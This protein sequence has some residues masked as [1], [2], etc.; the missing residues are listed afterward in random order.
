MILFR[1]TSTVEPFSITER[2]PSSRLVQFRSCRSRPPSP[3][4]SPAFRQASPRPL[5]DI[6]TVSRE[7]A[8]LYSLNANASISRE[9]ARDLA[10]TATYLFTRGNRLPVIRNINLVPSGQQL[11]DGR[12]VFGSARVFSGSGN[13]L[14]AESVGQ[15]VYNGFNLTLT[16]RFSQGFE[17]FATYIWSHAIDDAP[18]QN[19]ID[20]SNF[21]LSDPTNRRRDRG[22]SLTDRRHAFNGNLL[23][24]P[25][26]QGRNRVLRYLVNGN[27]IAV[28]ATI[29]SGDVFNMGTNRVLNGD[30]LTSSTF[31]QQLPLQCD[32]RSIRLALRNR[33][34]H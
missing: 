4:S 20:S 2:L 33:L 26:L 29:Q 3:R 17:M 27:L 18:E 32:C 11:A 34:Y 22:N 28:I 31:Q 13:I 19:N 23:Y 30:P 24:T 12:P 16:K 9:I 25:V 1:P 6:T 5:Q 21:L 8:S 10:L 15:S 7:F 14:A